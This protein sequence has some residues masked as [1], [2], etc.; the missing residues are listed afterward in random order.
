MS[1]M[2]RMLHPHLVL[3]ILEN[4]LS[5]NEVLEQSERGSQVH[6]TYATVM[7]QRH[8]LGNYVARNVLA[9]FRTCCRVGHGS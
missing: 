8:R 1:T 7:D 3:D 9:L 2:A 6:C 5:Y 4:D